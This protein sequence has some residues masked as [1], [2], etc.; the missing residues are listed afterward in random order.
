MVMVQI[1]NNTNENFNMK[2]VMVCILV[3]S[4]MAQALP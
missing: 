2:L 4:L 3:E 1:I